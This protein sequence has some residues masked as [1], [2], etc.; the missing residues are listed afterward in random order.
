[1]VRGEHRVGTTIREK[2]HLDR[3]IGEGGMAVVYAATHRN[4]KRFAIKMLHPELSLNE[5]VRKRFLREGYVANTVDHPAAV[6]VVDDDIAEDGAAFLVMELLNGQSVEDVRQNAGGTLPLDGALFVVHQLLDVLVSA[7]AKGIVHRDL[8]PANLFLLNDGNVKVLDFGIARVR[9]GAMGAGGATHTGALMGTPAFLPPEQAAGRTRE[10]DAQ[11]DVW[12]VG[13]TLF[14]MLTNEFVYAAENPAQMV[15]LAATTQA[16]SIG[17]VLPNL[18]P[19]VIHLV[20]AAL[21]F[22]KASRWPSAQAM[23]AELTRVFTS[24]YGSAPSPS[25]TRKWLEKPSGDG[26]AA[27]IPLQPS[28]PQYRLAGGTTAQPVSNVDGGFA[29]PPITSRRGL[30]AALSIAAVA[31]LGVAGFVVVPKLKSGAVTVDSA[32]IAIPAT[33]APQAS[34]AATTPSAQ[35]LAPSATVSALASAAPVV[36]PNAPTARA[37]STTTKPTGPTASA[38][39]TPSSTP[40]CN[41]PYYIDAAGHHQY[42]AGCI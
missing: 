13:A 21:A 12:A 29:P 22:S 40:Q 37:A 6:V 30:F 35:S 10:I 39:S 18:P 2:Y 14:T 15:V 19:P 16:R 32:A 20:D 11:T 24:L 34:A 25:T 7:H 9:D 23:Q 33:L 27:T 4:A 26:V 1:M 38:K 36:I 17:S 31:L 41:P 5:D 42:K 28:T 3:L 8:K